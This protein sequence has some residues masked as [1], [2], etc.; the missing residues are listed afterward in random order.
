MAQHPLTNS[1]R[2]FDRLT[3]TPLI[4]PPDD[5]HGDETG[6][7]LGVAAL[8]R[9]LEVTDTELDALET[10]QQA[11]PAVTAVRA[12]VGAPTGAQVLAAAG[13]M[14][15]LGVTTLQAFGTALEDLRARAADD[16]AAMVRE[17]DEHRTAWPAPP[18]MPLDRERVDEAAPAQR[19]AVAQ[20]DPLRARVEAGEAIQASAAL[21]SHRAVFATTVGFG[22][23]AGFGT[24]TTTLETA[25]SFPVFEAVPPVLAAQL[26]TDLGARLDEVAAWATVNAPDRSSDLVVALR[27]S[28]PPQ[29]RLTSLSQAMTELLRRRWL[30]PIFRDALTRRTLQPLGLLHLE[31]LDLTPM[32]IERGEFLY[33]LPLAPKEKVTLA[34]REWTVREEQFSELISDRLENFSETGVAQ[35]DDIALSSAAQTTHSDT[36]NMAQPMSANSTGVTLTSPVSAGGGSSVVGDTATREEARES[37]RTVTSK[38]SARTTRDHKTSFTV[39]TVAGMEDFTAHVL[40]NPHADKVMLVDYYAR[41]RN[42]RCDLYRQGVRLAYD[43]VLPDPG[44]RLRS[45]WNELQSIE[46]RLAVEFSF[47]VD[48]SDITRGNW[49]SYA[50]TYGVALP[51]PPAASRIVEAVHMIETETPY[52][53]L[54]TDDGIKWTTPQRVVALAV[55]VPDGYQVRSLDVFA[56]ARGWNGNTLIWITAIA[57][58][59]WQSV[60]ADAAGFVHL[61]WTL[62]PLDVPNTGVIDVAFRMQTMLNGT[63]KLTLAAEPTEVTMQSWRAQCFSLLRDAAT[64]AD[65]QRRAYLRDRAATLR[66]QIAADDPLRL[67]RMERE[68]VMR[69]VLSWLFPGFDDASSV[70]GGIDPAAAGNLDS[71]TWQRIM[72]YG[73]YIKFVQNAIDWDHV[74]VFLYPYFWDTAWHERSKL[75]LEHP[76]RLHREFLRAG[77]ARVIIAIQPGYE[78]EVVSLLDKGQLGTLAPHSRFASVIE[79]VVT[80]NAAFR[81]MAE[82]LYEDVDDGVVGGGDVDDGDLGGGAAER[83]GDAAIPGEL[84]GSWTNHTPTAGID[85]DVTI[86]P[87]IVG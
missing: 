8:V 61:D 62:G 77:A 86:T 74:A 17:L 9:S 10:H 75:Y 83:G 39:T 72:E 49:S 84:V 26:G 52:V 3:Y 41:M 51:A 54:T 58:Q 73:E 45:R 66:R 13:R 79:D 57:G 69:M 67:R 70:L 24:G 82:Q 21:P 76:D 36:L 12:L 64:V 7:A 47:P 19:L 2:R 27:R 59:S 81:E 18:A 14:A 25:G 33:S 16:A 50:D 30:A 29:L 6:D 31:R 44:S 87:V 53:T 80:A 5:Q 22:S 23:A 1:R 43:V 63:L 38:A 32:D 15:E 11:G 55:S 71:T 4:I 42:W 60:D 56:N 34:H 68:Q 40:E 20:Q 46:D 48:A 28:L 37:A 78:E 35:S 85:M 65:G